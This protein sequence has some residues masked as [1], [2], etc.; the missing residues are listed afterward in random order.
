MAYDALTTYALA[1]RLARRPEHADLVPT[2]ADMQYTLGTRIKRL[3]AAA[4]VRKQKQAAAAAAAS[5]TEEK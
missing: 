2:V 4:L 1:Q 5:S 3:K